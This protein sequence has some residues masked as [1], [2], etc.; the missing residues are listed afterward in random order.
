MS[1]RHTLLP[2]PSHIRKHSIQ[3]K[4]PKQTPAE[5]MW[6]RR[7]KPLLIIKVFLKLVPVLS[8]RRGPRTAWI[9]NLLLL[10]PKLIPVRLLN[11]AVVLKLA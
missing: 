10:I 1:K 3:P 2:A 6:I 7:V 5:T 4:A 8:L 9:L 11:L